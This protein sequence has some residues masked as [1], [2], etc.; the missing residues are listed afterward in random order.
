[1]SGDSRA[2]EII[3]YSFLVA[4]AND[5]TIDAD[6]LRFIE[7]LALKIRQST[8]TSVPHSPASSRVSTRKH[9]SNP[10]GAR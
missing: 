10:C 6:E 1:M 9:L 2:S 8:T 4:L 3:S 5:R 7:K